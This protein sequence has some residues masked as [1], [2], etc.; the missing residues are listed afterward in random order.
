MSPMSR[1][2]VPVT[3]HGRPGAAAA[4]ARAGGRERHGQHVG[5]PR[6]RPDGPTGDDVAFPQHDRDAAAG[7]GHQDGDRDI[8]AGREDRGRPLAGQDRRA[9]GTDTARRSGSRTAW[10]S[11]SAVRS[12]RRAS[13]R[14][15]MPAAGTSVASSPRWPPS[16][17]SSGASGRGAERPGDGQRRV[18]VSAR[19]PGRDQQSHRRSRSP[20]RRSR[21]RSRAGSRPRRS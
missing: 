18:D 7:G 19:S 4:S 3:K 5:E 12:E 21:A 13:R 16:Q 10:T 14:S 1:M 8:A 11:A 6:G 15:G 2:G 20:S 9:C 17:R